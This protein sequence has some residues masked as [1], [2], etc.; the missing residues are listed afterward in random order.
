MKDSMFVHSCPGHKFDYEYEDLFSTQW[1][2]WTVHKS[3]TVTFDI[4]MELD[5]YDLDFVLYEADSINDQCENIK[6]LRCMFSG[7]S[8]DINGIIIPDLPCYQS[9]GLSFDENDLIEKGGCKDGQNSYLKYL[10]LQEGKT[11]YLLVIN[12]IAPE[13]EVITINFCGSA[14]LGPDDE[15]CEMPEIGAGPVEENEESERLISIGP[16]PVNDFLILHNT[17]LKDRSYKNWTITD[18][19]GRIS[20]IESINESEFIADISNLSR[21]TYILSYLLEDQYYFLKFY[22]I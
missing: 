2:K 14:L 9:T 22:K 10:D 12:F 5:Q 21:G 3:G 16:N 13:D 20:K 1:I 19:F 8:T 4:S 17:F 6:P 7:Y 15:I 11:Y 18:M